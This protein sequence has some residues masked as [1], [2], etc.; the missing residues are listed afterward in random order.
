MSA[1]RTDIFASSLAAH[2]DRI[3]LISPGGAVSY[4]DLAA[5]VEDVARRLGDRRRLVLIVGANRVEPI[6]AYLGALSAGHPV[7]LVPGDDH[8]RW[9]SLVSAYDPDV[10]V[11]EVGGEWVFQERRD[12][13]A[14]ELHPDLALLLST[15]GS[16]GSPKLV[17]LSVENVQANAESIADF[18]GIRDADRAATTLPMHYCY[19]LS[20]V[21]SHLLRGAGLIVTDLSVTDDCFWDLFRANHGTTFAGVPYTFDLLDRTGFADLA[22]PDLRYI[23]AAGGRLSPDRVR[24][25]AKSGHRAGWEL[26]VM[27]GQT[28]A[29]ARMA[30][31]PPELAAQHPEAIGVP[32][33]GGSFTLEPIPDHPDPAA[34]E[35]VYAGPNVM[36]GYARTPADLRL[37]RTVDVLRTGDIARRGRDGLYEVV[38]RRARFVKAYGLRV[39]LDQAERALDRPGLTATCVGDDGELIVAVEGEHDVPRLRRM[40]ARE[41]GLPVAA[42]RVTCLPGLPRLPSGKPDYVAVS[43]LTRVRA[44]PPAAAQPGHVLALFAELLDRPDATQDSTFVGL[45]GDSLSYVEM[46]VRL[47]AALG[48][49]P[50]DWHTTPIRDLTPTPRRRTRGR[51][52]ETSVALR[53]VAIIFIVAGHAGLFTI[54]GGAHVLVAVAGFNFARF[55]LSPV[56]RLERVRRQLASVARIVVP[57]VA[58]IAVTFSWADQY[59]LLNVVLLNAVLGPQT[60]TPQWHFFFVEVLTYILLAMAALLAIPWV[61]RA[62]RR[63]PFALA[64][65]LL[66]VGLVTRFGVIDLGVPHTKPVLWLFALGWATAKATTLPQRMAVTAVTVAA[67]PGFF[68]NPPREAVIISGLLLLIWLPVVRCPAGLSHVVGVLASSSLYIYLT[69]WQIYPRLAG[70]HPALA[71]LACLG[72]GIIYWVLATAVMT[73]CPSLRRRFAP[74]AHA[75]G[76]IPR[77]TTRASTCRQPPIPRAR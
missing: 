5:Q 47:E 9:E 19:G 58:W 17:R 24:R 11:A 52:L 39:D 26:V 16:T 54:A 48:H 30:Y 64:A 14:H 31:L 75:S 18:L 12:G 59:N 25:Y 40:A 56:P 13:S 69:H 32:I 50:P 27:Y 22:L 45:G 34:G 43:E 4:R 20:V 6:V 8:A 10:V 35:L 70:D 29:T 23:T 76:S 57:S 63:Y 42:I 67:V 37:G 72:V 15:S 74:H 28:E 65:P 21:N 1:R 38:G 2:G 36:L 68:G 73:G 55:Q 44:Q 66:A 61:D 41:C 49:L 77:S 7:L 71:V 46:S 3:A 62:E 51:T 60:W 53:A 33:P